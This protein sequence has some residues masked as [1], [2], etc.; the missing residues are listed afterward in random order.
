[1]NGLHDNMEVMD[2]LGAVGAK[3]KEG[4]ATATRTLAGIYQ[5][6]GGLME[7]LGRY[8]EAMRY[9][10]QMDELAESLA[11]DNPGLLDA[12]RR[13]GQQQDHARPIRDEP[14]W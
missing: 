5:R 1:M 10:R 3:D 12:R 13:P 8:D 11:A 2:K 14:A 6:A 7:E 9:Y 4:A